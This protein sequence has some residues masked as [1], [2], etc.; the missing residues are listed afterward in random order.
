MSIL[1]S[2]VS[3]HFRTRQS[4]AG[5][6]ARHGGTV[7]HPP[8]RRHPRR[9]RPASTAAPGATGRRRRHSHQACREQQGKARLAAFDR[10]PDEAAQSRFRALRRARSSPSELHYTGD[11]NDSA[12]M[13]IWLH[14][15]VM[16]KLA[17]NG[18]KVPDELRK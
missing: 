7:R 1:G 16:H 10:R 5:L 6:P 18:G 3:T 4:R 2:I 8:A 11:K 17:E 9:P 15:Q 13:N 12:S 14:K